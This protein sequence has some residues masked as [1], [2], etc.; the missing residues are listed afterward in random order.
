MDQFP[1]LRE[2]QDVFPDEI[3]RIPPKRDLDFTIDII[4]S[5]STPISRYPYHMNIPELTK[6]R[7]QLQKLLDK[8]YVRPN[9]SPWGE[10]VF[11]VK[12]K[13]DTFRMW[14]DYRQL[15]KMIIKNKYPLPRI[16][17]LFGQIVGD[18]IF[19][20]I[21]LSSRYHQVRVKEED[22]HKTALTL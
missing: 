18:K 21:Y 15:N 20:K 13:Y 7:M 17:D 2:F 9:V 22:I 11:F 1:I 3:P 5:V 10:M 12:N 19:S 4:P 14:I 16:H 8:K 6:L